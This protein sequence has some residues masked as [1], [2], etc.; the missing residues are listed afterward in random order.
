MSLSYKSSC[1][2][3]CCIEQLPPTSAL[4]R[5]AYKLMLLQSPF[6]ATVCLNNLGFV[7]PSLVSSPCR[8]SRP[9]QKSEQD[10]L[11]SFPHNPFVLTCASL[12]IS[13]SRGMKSIIDVVASMKATDPP[14]VV[15]HHAPSFAFKPAALNELPALRKNPLMPPTSVSLDVLDML[16]LFQCSLFNESF[17]AKEMICDAAT[18]QQRS[19][20]KT[21]HK[22]MA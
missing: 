8:S 16:L 10:R 12:P 1:S 11:Y 13:N 19:N 3:C 20:A 18:Q 9:Q 2:F 21:W 17:L 7:S 22:S 5:K 14:F 6:L 4:Q 15:S